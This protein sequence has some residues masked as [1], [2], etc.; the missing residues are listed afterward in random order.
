MRRVAAVLP[1]VAAAF[2]VAAVHYL[3]NDISL[4][5]GDE[6]FLWY[7]ARH[8]LLGRVPIRDFQAYDPGRYYWCAALFKLW[9]DGV[10]PLRLAC[11]AFQFAGLVFGLLA[12]RRV[13]KSWPS[14]FFAG[15]FAS[16]FMLL[17][18]RY[19]T[20]VLPLIAVFFAVR[21]AEQ[22]SCRR[23]AEAGACVGV[24]SWFSLNHAFYILASFVLLSVYLRIKGFARAGK[25]EA[26]SF[27]AGILAGCLPWIVSF[28]LFPGF[29]AAY[30][31]TWKAAVHAFGAGKMQVSLAVPWPWAV[32]WRAIAAELPSF[33]ARVLEYANRVSIGCL[34]LFVASCYL[35]AVPAAA[36]LRRLEGPARALFAASLC[37]GTAYLGHICARRDLLYLGEGIFPVFAGLLS[38]ASLVRAPF[39]KA[40][41]AALVLFLVLGCLSAGLRSA[42]VF[43]TMAPKQWMT[44]YAV[45]KD[46]IWL[47]S[48]RAEYIDRFLALLERYAG[49]EPIFLSPL[50]P[51]LYCLRDQESPV[52]ELYFHIPPP[53][54]MEEKEIRQ[55]EEKKVDWAVLANLQIEERREHTFSRS[56]PRLWDYFLKNFEYVTNEGLYPG[57][58]LMK[59]K[60]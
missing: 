49:R 23:Y 2:L 4:D 27:G 6:G 44:P 40:F 25:R 53:P 35:A 5:F 59:R 41:R 20:A 21:L 10:M 54:G 31:E 46:K 7:G 51:A 28:A 34:F 50:L 18:C 12:L 56:H 13:V 36:R 24:L 9:R 17:P 29:A 60:P 38:A 30:L 57:Y 1:V 43:K 22:P 32:S 3:H 42:I 16:L 37:V 11:G 48:D 14:L 33:H 15:L 58:F 19:F 39:Q 8:V 55:L 52:Y 26:A 47:T 45:G